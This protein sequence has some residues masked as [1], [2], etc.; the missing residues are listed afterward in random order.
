[1]SDSSLEVI[2]ARMP[3]ITIEQSEDLIVVTKP[4]K[5]PNSDKKWLHFSTNVFA[6][7]LTSAFSVISTGVIFNEC[8]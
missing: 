7:Q 6:F 3:V 4:V 1:M 2:H 5:F 8:K